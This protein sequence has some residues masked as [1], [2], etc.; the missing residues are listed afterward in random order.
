ML[1]H[2]AVPDMS[3]LCPQCH[4]GMLLRGTAFC[5]NPECEAHAKSLLVVLVSIGKTWASDDR[6]GTA[7]PTTK[8]YHRARKVVLPG[9]GTT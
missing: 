8:E 1:V 6:A 3:N 9:R 5:P 2:Q 7:F 4:V